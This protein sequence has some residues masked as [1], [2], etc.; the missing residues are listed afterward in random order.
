M[1][2]DGHVCLSIRAIRVSVSVQR[3]GLLTNYLLSFQKM[4]HI[5]ANMYLL[6]LH[7]PHASLSN[8][9]LG[10]QYHYHL[11]DLHYKTGYA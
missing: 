4:D 10:V 9:I 7:L 1:I 2:R 3:S 6:H 8:H 11:H 5:V